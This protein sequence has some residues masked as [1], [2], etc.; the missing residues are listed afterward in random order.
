MNFQELYMPYVMNQNRMLD[1]LERGTIDYPQWVIDA[2]MDFGHHVEASY[3]YTF[4]LSPYV[5]PYVKYRAG[6]YW[7]RER[8][9]QRHFMINDKTLLN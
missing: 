8:K 6:E 2:I 3:M 5:P 4:L 1:G 7:L 9:V